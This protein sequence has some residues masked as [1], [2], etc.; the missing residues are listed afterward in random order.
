MA[1]RRRSD[2]VKRQGAASRAAHA[3]RPCRAS[4][5]RQPSRLAQPAQQDHQ[6]AK[7]R[8]FRAGAA[9]HLPLEQPPPALLKGPSQLAGC[10][11]RR[12]PL[13]RR[14]ARGRRFRGTRHSL[15]TRLQGQVFTLRSESPRIE[16]PPARFPGCTHTLAT[17]S[18][19]PRRQLAAGACDAAKPSRRRRRA[20]AAAA[21]AA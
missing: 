12:S 2:G 13:T 14:R 8:I 15:L 20:I 10:V 6:T 11:A 5:P 17:Y 1:K 4:S 9:E 18:A 19:R 7:W 16:P 3:S 21:A